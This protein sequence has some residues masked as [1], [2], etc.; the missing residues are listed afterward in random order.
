MDNLQEEIHPGLG[1]HHTVEE[2]SLGSRGQLQ[3][4]I[5]HTITEEIP[6][7][8]VAPNRSRFLHQGAT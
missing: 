7:N 6:P 2:I 1:S 3:G 4:M 5:L 8:P